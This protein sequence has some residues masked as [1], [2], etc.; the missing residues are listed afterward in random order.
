MNSEPAARNVCSLTSI[1]FPENSF[2][3]RIHALI[4]A[5]DDQELQLAVSELTRTA[6]RLREF[7]ARAGEGVQEIIA[8]LQPSILE[9]AEHP[10]EQS[11]WGILIAKWSFFGTILRSV[12][13]FQDSAQLFQLLY[14]LLCKKDIDEEVVTHKGLPLFKLAL[15]SLSGRDNKASGAASM[16]ATLAYLEDVRRAG[17]YTTGGAAWQ[18]LRIQLGLPDAQVKSLA[19]NA[20]LY[21]RRF[22]ELPIGRPELVWLSLALDPE[23]EIQTGA[24]NFDSDL[25][26][27]LLDGCSRQHAN[28]KA[29]G[30]YLEFFAGY[31]FATVAGWEVRRYERSESDQ[32]IDLIIRNKR[33]E[34][35]IDKEL[36]TYILV[37]CKNADEH[38]SAKVIRDFAGKVL[39]TG[40]NTG[41][42]LSRKEIR[43]T[44]VGVPHGAR[45][46]VSKYWHRSGLVMIPLDFGDINKLIAGDLSVFGM[47]VR[48][49]ERVR[50]D[51]FSSNNIDASAVQG[52]QSS[53]PRE[54]PNSQESSHRPMPSEESDSP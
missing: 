28:P 10:S 24:L 15:C 42:L 20:L 22:P 44:R 54:E 34:D 50:L 5:N 33:T 1:P 29:Q 7:S 11:P 9:T 25:A 27:L 49:Y 40:C 48:G 30:D 18:I 21:Q 8:H 52:T 23:F 6:D 14:S 19:E 46:T 38:P 16:W 39:M 35:P 2:Y 32:Q 47:V 37:E 12:G 43:G 51:I 13:N 17:N 41:I 53:T 4:L 3:S 26:A 31:L 45:T 36:G